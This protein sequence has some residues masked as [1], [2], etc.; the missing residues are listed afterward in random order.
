MRKEIG[1]IC[2]AKFITVFKRYEKKYLLSLEK[3]EALRKV[4]DEHMHVD[5]YG[6]SLIQNIYYD[7]PDFYLIRA[8]IEK[9]L[10]KEKLRARCY[11]ECTDE[12]NTFVE[13]K[14]KYD[15][16]VYK[17]RVSME[18]RQ[19]VDYL[20]GEAPPPKTTQITNEIDW[21]FKIYKGLAPA[22]YVSYERIAMAS[23]ENSGLRITFDQNITYRNYDLDLR[24]GCYGDKL[25]GEDCYL[26]EIKIPGAMPI[27]L[28]RTL[29]ELKI[30]P[31]SYSKY[32]NA[33]RTLFQKKVI[34]IGGNINA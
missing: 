3:Y 9:P 15:K 20:A 18:Y 25:I 31:T 12:H 26:M 11:G 5:K 28:A 34:K 30:Y 27:W 17:R 29:E 16:V 23:K 2:T 24:K 21:F 33:Y 1:G 10:Y 13:I 4:L 8:S 22:M 32:G 19:A 6:R 7:T 14:K